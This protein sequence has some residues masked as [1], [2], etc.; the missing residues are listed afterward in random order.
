MRGVRDGV[1]LRGTGR[2][3]DERERW[4][5]LR[6]G[7]GGP[8]S[9]LVVSIGVGDWDEWE[10]GKGSTSEILAA[11][12]ADEDFLIGSAEEAGGHGGKIEFPVFGKDG[13]ETA[14]IKFVEEEEFVGGPAATTGDV[15]SDVF[16]DGTFGVYVEEMFFLF[17]D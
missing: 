7:I 16:T 12:R 2:R 11:Q 5:R 9:L 17:L 3:R 13:F 10:E 4:D 8:L 6:I 14:H 15:L 1:G